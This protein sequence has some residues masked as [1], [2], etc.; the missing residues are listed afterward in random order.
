MRGRLNIREE[1]ANSLLIE[2]LRPLG[3]T[4]QNLYIKFD[5]LTNEAM[6]AACTFLSR[7]PGKTPVILYDAAKRVARGVPDMFFVDAT[8]AFLS[9]AEAR[10]GKGRVVM[11]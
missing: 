1:R 4:G 7:Y 3:R 2:E 6:R 10:F 8:D 9:D 5:A 11:K